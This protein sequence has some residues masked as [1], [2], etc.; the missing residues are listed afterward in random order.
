MFPALNTE[1]YHRIKHWAI[2]IWYQITYSGSFDAH[3]TNR[4]VVTTPVK[5]YINEP[6]SSTHKAVDGL[7]SMKVTQKNLHEWNNMLCTND[8]EYL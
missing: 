8:Y 5:P 1:T 4:P 3:S 7:S 2:Q 6:Q